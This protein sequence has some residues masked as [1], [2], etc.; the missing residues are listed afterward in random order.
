MGI[1]AAALP[2]LLVTYSEK[3]LSSGLAGLINGSV[4][5]FTTI[6]AHFYLPKD[7]LTL[8]KVL[9]ISMGMSGLACVLFPNMGQDLGQT[10]SIIMVI[11]SSI[12]YAFGM[13][14][15]K[16]K[17][18]GLPPLIAPTWQLTIASLLFFPLSLFIDKPYSLPI[19][20]LK[21]ISATIGLALIGSALAFVVYY[22][23]IEIAGASYV[24]LCTLL[25]PLLAVF[26]GAV[27][28][29]EKLD[30]HSYLGGGLI[31]SALG[32]STEMFLWNRLSRSFRR[33]RWPKGGN[34]F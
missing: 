26:L 23:I 9:S 4:P 8:R 2:F 13:V 19:P 1:A 24:S 21:A 32:V 20:S 27:F 16:K 28:L 14:Y 17:L 11:I 3:H 6:M 7:R 12:G 15:S 10:G 22:R 18:L 33:K 25:F 29:N 34:L 31:I 30:W 5:V